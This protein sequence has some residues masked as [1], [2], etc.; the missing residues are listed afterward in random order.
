VDASPVRDK[1]KC[2]FYCS[3]STFVPISTDAFPELILFTFSGS[4]EKAESLA[5][6]ETPRKSQNVKVH[7][8]VHNSI[9]LLSILTRVTPYNTL[10]SFFFIIH[11]N[12]VICDGSFIPSSG[13]VLRCQ[14]RVQ[15][16][17]LT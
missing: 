10:P 2:I 16:S 1:V 4:T 7:D 9:P 14:H 5:S 12:S 6:Q 11:F 13:L 15:P 8:H 3:N 17:V